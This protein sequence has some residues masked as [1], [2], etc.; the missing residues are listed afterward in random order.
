MTKNVTAVEIMKSKKAIVHLT[1]D[2]HPPPGRA[3]APIATEAPA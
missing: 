3:V 1:N 2:A